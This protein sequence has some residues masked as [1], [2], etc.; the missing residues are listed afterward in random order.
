MGHRNLTDFLAQ[1]YLY[2]CLANGLPGV[3]EYKNT[4][5]ISSVGKYALSKHLG[6]TQAKFNKTSRATF[7]DEAA[8]A[9]KSKPG[10]GFYKA[11]S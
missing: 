1:V 6:G 8:K 11:P 9:E 2:L 3:G 7:L 4:Q 10:P 5:P